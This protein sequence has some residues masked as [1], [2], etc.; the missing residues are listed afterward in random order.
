MSK[1]TA[2]V[3]AG[4]IIFALASLGAGAAPGLA[5]LLVARCVQ[6]F[7][8]TLLLAGSLPVLTAVVAGE[9]RARRWWSAAAAVGAATGPALGGLLTQLAD[10][11]AIFFIKVPVGI[12]A[13]LANAHGPRSPRVDTPLDLPGQAAA[14]VAIAS[15]T[16]AV[17]EA[18][19]EG[20]G[21]APALA[22]F[23]V[24]AIAAVA[25]LTIERRSVH[26][27]VPLDLF[28]A[29][30]VGSAIDVGD[31]FAAMNAVYRE[32]FPTEPPTRATVG[33]TALADTFR[34]EIE[35]IAAR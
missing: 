11:R 9:G 17:I 24:F 33:V 32:V 30:L 6:G 3:L 4:S 14:I 28:R 26:P 27:A 16:F 34:V 15:L 5:A 23:T 31:D 35:V 19:H 2:L 12:V 29:P 20:I 25:F 22:A 8:A 13:V 10:W 7:G 21:S 18:G 1:W